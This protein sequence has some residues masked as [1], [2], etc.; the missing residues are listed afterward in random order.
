[1]FLVENIGLEEM[2]IFK[3]NTDLIFIFKRLIINPHFIKRRKTITWRC[4]FKCLYVLT[5]T[6]YL[7]LVPQDSPTRLKSQ[8]PKAEEFK[9]QFPIDCHPTSSLVLLS[10]E[11]SERLPVYLKLTCYQNCHALGTLDSCS[12]FCNKATLAMMKS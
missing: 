2:K 4:V 12:Y 5:I 8:R 9:G 10:C 6:D 7:M 1:M 11:L 3:F